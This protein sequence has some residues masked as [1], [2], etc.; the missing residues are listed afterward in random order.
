MWTTAVLDGRRDRAV[1]ARGGGRRRRRRRPPPSR[2][3]SRAQPHATKA[4]CSARSSASRHVE[5]LASAAC[6]R[7]ARRRDAVDAASVRRWL[8][9]SRGGWQLQRAVGASERTLGVALTQN[10][11]QH[12]ERLER[13]R[14]LGRAQRRRRSASPPSA[15]RADPAPRDGPA[16]RS[17]GGRRRRAPRRAKVAR[18][19]ALERA[20]HARRELRDGALAP[21]GA[22]AAL[23]WRVPRCLRQLALRDCCVVDIARGAVLW[24]EFGGGAWS[25]AAVGGAAAGRLSTLREGGG[26]GGLHE[27]HGPSCATAM[28][29]VYMYDARKDKV[30][31]QPSACDFARRTCSA[32][33]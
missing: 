2:R 6:P 27:R 26:C 18:V 3:P 9:A 21:Q 31:R 14:R 20:R 19:G 23:P 15:S 28:A 8:G 33:R 25:S 13:A 16:A 17:S 11:L 29:G 22:A 12:L 32:S 10:R 4:A 24:A 30:G 5:R 7:R 1:A